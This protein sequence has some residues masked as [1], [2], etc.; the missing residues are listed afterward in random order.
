MHTRRKPGT[1]NQAARQAQARR[2]ARIIHL[3]PRTENPDP[4]PDNRDRDLKKAS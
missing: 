1:S 3:K 4:D 2:L